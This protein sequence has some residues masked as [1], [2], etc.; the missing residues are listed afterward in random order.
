MKNNV[1][2]TWAN[3]K[4]TAIKEGWSNFDES[5]IDEYL[6]IRLNEIEGRTN[7]VEYTDVTIEFSDIRP[8]NYDIGKITYQKIIPKWNAISINNKLVWSGSKS[9]DASLQSMIGQFGIEQKP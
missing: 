7:P 1:L 4:K 3:L 2:A 8:G 5:K 9:I 6:Y